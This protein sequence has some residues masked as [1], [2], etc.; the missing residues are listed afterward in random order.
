MVAGGGANR[1]WFFYRAQGNESVYNSTVFEVRK[2]IPIL[3]LF[4]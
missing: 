3:T 4:V 1:Q 2:E